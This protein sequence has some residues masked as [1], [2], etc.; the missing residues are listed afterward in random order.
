MACLDNN[1]GFTLIELVAVIIIVGILAAIAAQKIGS[2]A[3]NIKAE[4]TMLE[5]EILA[6]AIVGN[7]LLYDNGVRSDFG[8]VGDIGAFPPNLDALTSNPGYG[9]WNGP[10]IKNSFEQLSSDFKQ[11]SWQV[12]YILSGTQITSSGSGNNI[13]KYI[14]GSVDGILYNNVEG[15]IFDLDGTPPGDSLNAFISIRLTFPNGAGGYSTLSKTPDKGGYFQFDSIPIG[16][17]TLEIIYS[18]SGDMLR[19][20][21]SVTPGSNLYEQNFL[22]ANEW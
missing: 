20:L 6:H 13:V 10:Y 11:D 15:N 17:H 3:E 22:T 21:V 5:M 7:E 18:P 12:D 19:H 4:E 14:C 2:V 8:Y 16:N 9:T 1:K